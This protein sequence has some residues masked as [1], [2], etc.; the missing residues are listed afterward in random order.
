[1]IILD[2]ESSGIDT[3]RCGIWQIGA[4]ELEN[5]EN[6]FLQEG[7]I[8]DEDVIEESALKVI[9]KTER[10]LRDK[11]KQPQEQLILNFL[12]WG[13]GIKEKI[14]T[15]QNIGWDLNFLQNKC[16]KYE[17]M[18]D[19]REVAG[20]RGVDLHTAAQIR[21]HEI[22]KK[23]FLKDK[24]S[25]NMNLSNVLDFCGIPDERIKMK[26]GNLSEVEREGKHHNALDD[27]KLE[28]ECFSRL[29]FGENLFQEY[30]QFPVPGVLKK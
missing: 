16:L 21:Y 24:G 29:M 13:K 7:R 23:Y 4:I 1:M 27:C 6:Y 10:E 2:I 19:F 17:I 12:N 30:K 9:G 15:G 18:N 14:I 8:D 20:Q 25:S 11:K 22:N 26:D 5:T 28:G 3:G